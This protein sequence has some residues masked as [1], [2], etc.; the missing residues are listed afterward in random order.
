M[1]R[2][3][4]SLKKYICIVIVGGEAELKENFLEW[5]GKQCSKEAGMKY[6]IISTYFLQNWKCVN[7]LLL[8]IKSVIMYS[9]VTNY[10]TSPVYRHVPYFATRRFH[11]DLRMLRSLCKHLCLSFRLLSLI[12]K[13]FSVVLIRLSHWIPWMSY[14]K[15]CTKVS[16]FVLY[17]SNAN[18]HDSE[19]AISEI[20]T[21]KEQ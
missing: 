16:I 13:F 15:R 1:F 18:S 19:S 8:P 11:L 2:D 10:F 21:R 12:R 9:S 5:D 17:P 20:S 4:V 7:L 14:L 6:V 3:S